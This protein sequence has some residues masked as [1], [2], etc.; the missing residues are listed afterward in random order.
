MASV[1]VKTLSKQEHDELCCTYAAL[2]L[3]DENLEISVSKT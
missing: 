3:H 2:L 1:D